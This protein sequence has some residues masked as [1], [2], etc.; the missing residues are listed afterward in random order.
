M[1]RLIG[2]LV[3]CVDRRIR[4]DEEVSVGAVSKELGFTRQYVSGKFHKIT[5]HLLSR[6]LKERRLEKA[7]RLLKDTKLKIS[8][9]SRLAGFDSENYFRQQFRL[10]FNMSP[11]QFRSKGDLRAVEDTPFPELSPLRLKVRA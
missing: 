7:A 5:G 3:S 1:D 11:R 6:Y 8:Q 10:R 9:I 2:D 4:Q